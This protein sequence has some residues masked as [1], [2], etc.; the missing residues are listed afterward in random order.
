LVAYKNHAAVLRAAAL[1]T[2]RPRVHLIGCGPEAAP[3]REL[4]AALG[5]A[6]QVD[7]AGASDEEVDAAYRAA[8]VVVCPSRHEGFGLTP[9]EAIAQGIAVVASDIPPHREFVGGHAQLVA[10]DDDTAMATAIHAALAAPA[11]PAAAGALAELTI[12]ACVAR[13]LPRLEALLRVD[14][15]G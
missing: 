6:V 14:A 5:I 15:P 12:E 13:L 8:S 3:L 4:G 10:L 1:V 2:P 11:K 9:M 7:D